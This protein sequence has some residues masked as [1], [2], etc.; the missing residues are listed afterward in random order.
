MLYR[1]HLDLE[2]RKS[3]PLNGPDNYCVENNMIFTRAIEINAV[4]HCNLSCKGC[5]HSSPISECKIYEPNVLEKDLTNISK[6]LK[7]E[8]VRVVGGEPLLHSNFF[9]I[10]K[11]I[12]LSGISDKICVVTNGLLLDRISDDMLNYIDK[13]EISIYPLSISVLEK[14]RNNAINLGNKGVKV[15][16]LEYT[17]FRESITQTPSFNQELVQLIYNTCQIAHNW[18]CITIDNNRIYRCPQSMINDEKTGNYEDSLDIDSINCI[19]DLL[20]F[21]ENNSYL[22]S[23]STCL[24]S[25]GKK[26]VHEQVNRELWNDLL[27]ENPEE[28]IDGEYAMQLVKTLEYKSDCLQRHRLN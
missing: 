22:N 11:T 21:L 7:A 15:R 17:D 20:S 8:F 27:P 6:F 3:L 2:V 13:I 10:L 28:G 25:V 19:D 16:L 5:S 12:K 18:R 1:E 14:I 23:C 9:E 24:G 26:I 4:R